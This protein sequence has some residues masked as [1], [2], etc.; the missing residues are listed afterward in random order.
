MRIG[1]AACENFRKTRCEDRVE[2]CERRIVLGPP[3]F[4]LELLVRDEI[5]STV[6]DACQC[7]HQ[8][9]EHASV[10]FASPNAL[11]TCDHA[12]VCAVLRGTRAE[13]ACFDY[14]YWVRKEGRED[15]RRGRSTQ[16][17]ERGEWRASFI[18][19]VR[20]YR[21]LRLAVPQEV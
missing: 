1:Q 13:H 21:I 3:S 2:V 15:T 12:W 16:V 7:G 5:E 19:A 14:P 18:A 10:A 6:T 17:V 11:E 20:S 8:P 9:M 4:G